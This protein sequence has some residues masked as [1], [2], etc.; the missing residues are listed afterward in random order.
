[1]HILWK[2]LPYISNIQVD[3]ADLVLHPQV[4][5][6]KSVFKLG[7]CQKLGLTSQ[8]QIIL[9]MLI[10]TWLK[11]NLIFSKP[12]FYHEQSYYLS[13]PL[14]SSQPKPG[15]SISFFFPISDRVIFFLGGSNENDCNLCTVRSNQN[16]WKALLWSKTR[17]LW[18]HIIH[19]KSAATHFFKIVFFKKYFFSEGFLLI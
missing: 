9:L 11:F 19:L 6:Q 13:S 1:M 12:L 16:N 15:K 8:H 14:Y 7:N 17:L 5:K 4:L 3:F 2:N 18:A 10:N